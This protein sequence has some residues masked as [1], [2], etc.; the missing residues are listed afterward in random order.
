MT[1]T[2]MT[3][4]ATATR[5]TTTMTTTERRRSPSARARILGWYVA[6]LGVS[7]VAALLLQRAFLLAQVTAT[8]DEGLDQEVAELRQLAGGID[9]ETGEPFGGDVAA[10]FDTFLARN[11][12]LEGEG[13]VTFVDGRP[14]KADV[15]GSALART[16]LVD[17]WSSI[18]APARGEFEA[19]EG[20]VRYVAVPLEDAGGAVLGV[21]AVAIFMAN[22]LAQVEEVVRLG[23]LVYGSIFLIASALAWVAAGGVLRPLRELTDAARSID[24]RD[25]SRRIPVGGDDEIAELGRTFNSMLDRLEQAFATQRRFID[26]AGHE[27][28]TPITVIRGNLE[29]MGDD[30]EERAQTVAL[31]TDELD[32]MARIVD[33][34]LVLAKAEQPDF[35]VAHPF[36]LG[37]LTRD[38]A[39]KGDALS[40]R[41]WK[42]DEVGEAVVVADRDRITQAV[43]NL[44]QNAIEHTPA[45]AELA[46]GSRL[47]GAEARIWV[48]DDGP[49]IPPQDLDRIFDRFARGRAGRRV[50]TGAGLGLAIVRTIAEAHD[51][52]VEVDSVSGEGTVFTLV[53][54]A[55]PAIE[56]EE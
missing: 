50:S 5:M 35:V 38:L 6:L 42:V 33:D 37:E 55:E 34:L 32:R 31:V 27:L 46:L 24:E 53:L 44:M 18:T 28:R 13:I 20:P 47:D 54:P 56:V 4:T 11:V 30:A 41:I 7:L 9:P 40:D 19:T 15:T 26:D 43:M 25:W 48:R 17:E 2:T 39:L 21:F 16:P 52:R 23:I 51:G 29:L 3:T 12:P 14:Y 1:T 10:I 8:A 45:T 49:G 22:R 36:D